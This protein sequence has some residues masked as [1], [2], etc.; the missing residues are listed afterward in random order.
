MSSTPRF[1]TRPPLIFL[2]IV[3]ALA[4]FAPAPFA[5]IAPGP[6]TNLLGNTVSIS[7]GASATVLPTKGKLFSTS[8]LVNNPNSRLPG[9]WVLLAWAKGSQAVVPWS[10]L[11]PPGESAKKSKEVSDKE[12]ATS[13]QKAAI[14]AANF[15]KALNPSQPLGWNPKDIKIAMHN[16]GGPSA[17][18]AFALTLIAKLKSPELIAGRNIAVT[19]EISENGSVGRIGGIDQKMIGAR[20]AGAQIFILPRQTCQDITR[21]PKGLKLIAVS[22]LGQAVH[23]LANPRIA[24][25][26]HC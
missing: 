14:A 20:A 23:A 8:V 3:L 21:R 18:L 9:I 16:V 17:G 2:S 1:L 5:V 13:Q 7:S 24:D 15:L 4:L 26:L 12:M 10:A 19:G 6:A 25:S 11:Y 22:T